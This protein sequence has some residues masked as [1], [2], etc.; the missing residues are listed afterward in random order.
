MKPLPFPR[1][2]DKAVLRTL[3]DNKHLAIYQEL[4]ANL[5]PIHA[6]YEAYWDADGNPIAANAPQPIALTN[7]MVI[8]LKRL[9]TSPPA[10]IHKQLDNL[11][12]RGSPNVCPMCGSLKT[13]SLDHVFPKNTFPEFSIFSKNLAPACDCNSKRQ[14]SYM[15]V[16]PSER[17][18]HPYFDSGLNRRLIRATLAEVNGSFRTPTIGLEVSIPQADPLFPAVRYHLNNV[19]LKNNVIAYLEDLW[20]KL[21][22]FYEDFF[23]LPAG[24]FSDADLLGAVDEARD[25]YDRLHD[26]PNNWGS[27]LLAGIANNLNAKAYLAQEIRNQ[28]AR[29]TTPDQF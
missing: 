16:N 22:R 7:S 9:Y 12:D 15:G 28:R 24:N 23:R 10:L 3:A 14:E 2:R 27:M 6:Q 18:L 1:I 29:I 19:V 11:R 26:T 13:G 5:A 20:P 21:L 4:R 25:R 8:A 17:V